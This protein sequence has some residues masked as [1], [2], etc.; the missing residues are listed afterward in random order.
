M[1]ISI[2]SISIIIKINISIISIMMFPF[3]DFPTYSEGEGG[4]KG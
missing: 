4:I 2:I 3:L 1:I